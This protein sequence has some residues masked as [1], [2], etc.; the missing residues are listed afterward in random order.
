MRRTLALVILTAAVVIIF[1]VPAKASQSSQAGDRALRLMR[2]VISTEAARESNGQGYGN[3]VDV[4][5]SPEWPHTNPIY[6]VNVLDSSSAE[7]GNY[8]VRMTTSNDRMHFQVSIEPSIPTRAVWRFSVMSGSLYTGQGPRLP[9]SPAWPV[10][11]G[12]YVNE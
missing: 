3:L 10:D 11:L 5:L 2:L 6:Q 9:C 1:R 8:L 12:V 4:M 7:A